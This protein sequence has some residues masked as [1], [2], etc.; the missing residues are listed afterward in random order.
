MNGDVR[1]YASDISVI[2]NSETVIDFSNKREFYVGNENMVFL[3]QLFSSFYTKSI[4]SLVVRS[5]DSS[6]TFLQHGEPVKFIGIYTVQ[7]FTGERHIPT[8]VKKLSICNLAMFQLRKTTSDYGLLSY[9]AYVNSV[10]KSVDM[11][12]LF[13]C[14]KNN[15]E[16]YVWFK[17]EEFMSTS[18]CKA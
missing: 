1:M 4:F 18:C 7:N 11:S 10:L 12:R 3:F 2:V 13:I 16:N 5:T 8:L 17:I 15:N 9:Y 14:Q 6:K